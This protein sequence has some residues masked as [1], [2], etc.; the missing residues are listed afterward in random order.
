MPWLFNKWHHQWGQVIP[1]LD[2]RKELIHRLCEKIPLPEVTKG[3]IVA[4]SGG[5]TPAQV[6][7]LILTLTIE[8]TPDELSKFNAD[9]IN[10]IIKSITGTNDK[11]VGFCSQVN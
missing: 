8:N 6:Q 10:R 1:T 7:G 3:Y 9:K 5:F 2:Q 4:N 11:K